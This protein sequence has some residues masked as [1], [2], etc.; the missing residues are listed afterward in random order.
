[1]KK[2]FFSLGLVSAAARGFLWSEKFKSVVKN[3]KK[4]WND[5]PR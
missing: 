4:N 3:P 5:F 2:V 1:M